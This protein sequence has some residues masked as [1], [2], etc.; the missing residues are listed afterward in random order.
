[1]AQTSSLAEWFDRDD[2]PTELDDFEA[3]AVMATPATVVAYGC[4]TTVL[5]LNMVEGF[6]ALAGLED[7]L[8]TEER[9]TLGDLAALAWQLPQLVMSC[10]DPDVPG[11]VLAFTTKEG[12]TVERIEPGLL[13]LGTVTDDS[14]RVELTPGIAWQLVAEITSLLVRQL[15]Q[16]ATIADQ[17]IAALE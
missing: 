1:M 7:E 17:L 2:G 9:F 14:V 13:A 12:I 5:V 15:A 10:S 8:V 11:E 6:L 3:P 4:N 16:T